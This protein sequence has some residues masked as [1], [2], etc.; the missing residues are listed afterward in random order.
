M[1]LDASLIAFS[2]FQLG[3]GGEQPCRWPTFAIGAFGEL[4]PHCGDGRQPQLTQQ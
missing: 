2:E 1:S 3:E 4:L